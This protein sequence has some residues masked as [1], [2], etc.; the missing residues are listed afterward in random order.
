M[1]KPPYDNKN[2]RWAM[3]LSLIWSQPIGALSGEVIVSP[4]PV[5]DTQILRPIYY[6]PNQAWLEEFTLTMGTSHLTLTS[7]Q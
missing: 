2:V 6:E 5:A 7:A 1:Q 4:W 3:A